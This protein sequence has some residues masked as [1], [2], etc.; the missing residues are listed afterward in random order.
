MQRVMLLRAPT[1]RTGDGYSCGFDR[2]LAMSSA[3][4]GSTV[5]GPLMTGLLYGVPPVDPYT[6]GAVGLLLML[7]ATAAS[8]VPALRASRIDP[9]VALRSE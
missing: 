8:L 7:V 1:A 4:R 3:D 5:T 9:S 6:F 2:T